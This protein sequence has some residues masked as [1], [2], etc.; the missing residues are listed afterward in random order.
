MGSP[1]RGGPAAARRLLV[2]LPA[3]A[4]PRGRRPEGTDGDGRGDACG[5]R[6]G[7]TT[8]ATG[9]A[10]FVALWRV[11]GNRFDTLERHIDRRF[12]TVDKRFEAADKRWAERFEA[13][14]AMN[15]ERFAAA[16]TRSRERFEMAEQASRERF[17]M[18]EQAS[19]ER[20][21][22][23]DRRWA[24]R[25]ETVEAEP[26]DPRG[27]LRPERPVR[28]PVPPPARAG[29]GRAGRPR[30]RRRLSCPAR[31]LLLHVVAGCTASRGLAPAGRMEA[32]WKWNNCC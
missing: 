19:R 26:G 32:G 6:H 2:A 28:R 18:A 24:E 21:E 23:M 10:L 8:V 9:L 11:Q 14:E 1:P 30:P 17:E 3:G 15:R 7:L 31:R 5:V 4:G 27:R 25:F 12:E 20:L 22:A 13:A 29:R 16:E